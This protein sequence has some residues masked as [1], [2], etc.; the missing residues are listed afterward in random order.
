MRYKHDLETPPGQIPE[1]WGGAN[2][3]TKKPTPS[4]LP[5]SSRT[6]PML[7]IFQMHWSMV[8]CKGGTR[9]RNYIE[10]CWPCAGGLST[11][12]AIGTQLRDAIN[13]GLTRPD[14]IWRYKMLD[15][16]A[17]TGR[18]PVSKHQI[19]PEYGE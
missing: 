11:V 13:S 12:A 17:E 9:Y 18:N 10:D 15:A 8:T 7:I 14:A 19:R 1:N 3:N 16:A 5:A 4:H 6:H 2:I